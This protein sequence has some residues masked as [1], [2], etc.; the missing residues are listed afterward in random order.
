MK[1]ANRKH[2]IRLDGHQTGVTLE[3]AFWTELKHIARLH[4]VRVTELLSEINAARTQGNLSSA[5]RVFVLE[6]VQRQ[7]STADSTTSQTSP[8]TL[9]LSSHLQ[10]TSE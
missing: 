9:R 3:A 6:H 1:S 5:I 10:N 2:S 7:S 4:G 8:Q